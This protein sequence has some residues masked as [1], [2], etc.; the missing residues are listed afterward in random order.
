M[1]TITDQELLKICEKWDITTPVNLG[2]KTAFAQGYRLA[3]RKALNMHVVSNCDAVF[4]ETS[5]F[6]DRDIECDATESD[7][8]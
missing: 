4:K 1:K 3:E 6:E 2:I 7:I 5:K 8:Y